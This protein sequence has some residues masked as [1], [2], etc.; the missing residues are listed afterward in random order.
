VVSAAVCDVLAYQLNILQHPFV[1][2]AGVGFDRIVPF[3][4]LLGSMQELDFK[5]FDV[6][7]RFVGLKIEISAPD[8]ISDFLKKIHD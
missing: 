1:L 3:S 6:L 4:P 5:T 2:Q 7:F 8:F